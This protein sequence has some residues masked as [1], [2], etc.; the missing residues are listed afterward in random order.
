MVMVHHSGTYVP[1]RHWNFLRNMLFLANVGQDVRTN[2][3]KLWRH[4]PPTSGDLQI[5]QIQFFKHE[6][7]LPE[8]VGAPKKRPADCCDRTGYPGGSP[9][10]RHP[11]LAYRCTIRHTRS[12][13]K[14]TVSA[15]PSKMK[16][17]RL[18]G[19]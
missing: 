1:R 15:K 8:P 4:L 19:P 12:A 7:F 11:L 9:V 17:R 5:L 16:F 2:L 10:A 13:F 6:Y 14:L 3:P 18:F